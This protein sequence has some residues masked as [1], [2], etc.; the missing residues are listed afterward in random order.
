MTNAVGPYSPFDEPGVVLPAYALLHASVTR[1]IGQ[2]ELEI[3]VH[4]LLN[5][6]VSGARRRRARCA[7]AAVRGVRNRALR[8]LSARGRYIRST[9]F[10]LIDSYSESVINPPASILLRSL[11]SRERI[12]TRSAAGGGGR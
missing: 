8:L 5:K 6:V 10:A 7:G 9:I 12:I 1:K 2:A 3:G 4:N 11:E